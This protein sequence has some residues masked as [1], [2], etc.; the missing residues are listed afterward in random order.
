MPTYGY[1]RVSTEGQDLEP[2]LVALQ[3]A[4]CGKIIEE[5]ASG[6]DRSRPELALS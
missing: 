2:Q 3:A 5:K 1:A 4:G 6:T